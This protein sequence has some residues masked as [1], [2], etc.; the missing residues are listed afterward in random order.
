MNQLAAQ[1]RLNAQNVVDVSAPEDAV[2]H[3]DF[4]WNNDVAANEFRKY[5]ARN[6]INGLVVVEEET[7]EEP[8]IRCFFMIEENTSNYTPLTVIMQN[9]N[10]ID[11]LKSKALA[12]LNAYWMKYDTIIK[13]VG[14]EEEMKSLR[15][16]MG[17]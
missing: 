4:E 9:A 12:E 8:P 5:Q 7:P 10:S 11:T 16:K 1:D 2:L 3:N 17:A 15:T 14:A 6:I 13:K